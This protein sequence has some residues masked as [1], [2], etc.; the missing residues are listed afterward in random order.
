MIH[1]K[2]IINVPAYTDDT[3]QFC[4]AFFNKLSLHFTFPIFLVPF[5]T[6]QYVF[7]IRTFTINLPAEIIVASDAT[8]GHQK[9]T[10]DR[11]QLDLPRSGH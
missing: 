6:E 9:V 8:E 2:F 5:L 1:Y 11:A 3:V 10:D 4:L 7:I